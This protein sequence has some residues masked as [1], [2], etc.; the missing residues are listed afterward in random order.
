MIGHVLVLDKVFPV[1]SEALDDYFVHG[2]LVHVSPVL[3]ALDVDGE[4]QL[5]DL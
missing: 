4:D 3:L 2:T 5:H 1:I